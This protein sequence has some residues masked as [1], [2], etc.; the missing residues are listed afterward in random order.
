MKIV[1]GKAVLRALRDEVQA[2]FGINLTDF[3][4][5]D[6]YLEVEVPSDMKSL[7]ARLEAFR[8]A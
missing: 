5:I 3:Q 6:E 2:D 8:L 4:I 7:I 1:P